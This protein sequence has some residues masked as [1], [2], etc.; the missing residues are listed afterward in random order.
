MMRHQERGRGI[1]QDT[2]AHGRTHDR[3]QDTRA[4]ALVAERRQQVALDI[5]QAIVCL[6]VI[7]GWMPVLG[8]LLG[9][10]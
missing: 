7:F 10:E 4:L 5:L 6:G 8:L 2:R 9:G 1:R 3:R